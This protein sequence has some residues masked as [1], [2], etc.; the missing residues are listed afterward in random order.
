MLLRAGGLET[1]ALEGEESCSVCSMGSDGIQQLD[2]LVDGAYH[3]AVWMLV[4]MMEWC[5]AWSPW[6]SAVQSLLF[7]MVGSLGVEVNRELEDLL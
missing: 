7:K 5:L 2:F 4:G 3:S 1:E 6:W